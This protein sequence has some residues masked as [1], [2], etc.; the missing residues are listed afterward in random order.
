MDI[1]E[2]QKSAQEQW[3]KGRPDYMGISSTDNI[4]KKLEEVIKLPS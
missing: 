1:T 3:E 2:D 4:I